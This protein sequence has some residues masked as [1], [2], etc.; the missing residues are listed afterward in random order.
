[1]A[2]SGQFE[3]VCG[4][5]GHKPQLARADCRQARE[6]MLVRKPTCDFTTRK[7][8]ESSKLAEAATT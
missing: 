5:I 1:M 3:V 8:C 6:M 4:P 2:V 7:N